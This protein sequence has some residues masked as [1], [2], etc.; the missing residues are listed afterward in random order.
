MAAARAFGVEG[1]DR[2]ALEGRDRVLDEA[3]FVERVGVDRHLRR[4]AR[5][6]R[7]GSCRSPPASCPSPRAASGRSRRPRPARA[8]RPAG[9]RCPCPGSRGSS[10][11]PRPP[12]ACA[13]MF[14]GPGVQVVAK[15]PVAG[16]VPPPII[17]VTPDI[18]ASSICCGQMKWMW[19]VDAAGGDDHAFAGDDLGARADDDV[20]ARLHVRVAGLADAGD[21]AVLDADVG[22]DDAPV[23]DDRRALVITVSARLGARR[24]GSAPCRRGSSCR[25]RTSPP[26]RSRGRRSSSRPR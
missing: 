13:A 16:P 8:A 24:A 7:R 23:V 3:R 14:H 25:R 2:A 6:R 19:R 22:L 18:S 11:R 20:D 9:W 10:G 21:A 5:R 12:A 17:V 15:V 1:V 4:R 26:R